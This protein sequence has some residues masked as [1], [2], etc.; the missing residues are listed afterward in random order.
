MLLGGAAVLLACL[1]WILYGPTDYLPPYV[2]GLATGLASGAAMLTYTVIKEAN[3]PQ[4]S[5]TAIG[6]INLLNFAFSALIGEVF[7]L[8]M[9][10]LSA[11]KPVGLGHYQITFQPL[12]YGV[13]L[14]M[15]LMLAL[16]ETGLATRVTTV[17]TAEAA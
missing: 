10:K 7:V 6:V 13:A 16:K 12:I 3:P 11:T 14:A 15:V 8:V 9:R 2:L 1:V 17:K 5:G 4:Y